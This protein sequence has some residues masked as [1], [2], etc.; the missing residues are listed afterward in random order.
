M[1]INFSA[2]QSLYN[3]QMN[4]LLANTGLTT[5]CLLNY[6]ITKKD[7]CPNCIYDPS[8]KK[9]AN[10]YKQ[11][12]PK[13]FV[14]GR[15]CPYCNGAGFNGLV[16]VEEAY[17][18]VIWE[19]KYWINK[20]INIQNPTGMIQT[21]C[22]RSLFDRLKKAKDLT[23]I[24][25]TNNNNPLFKLAEEPNPNGLGDNNYLICN[26]ERTGISSITESM[27]SKPLVGFNSANYL[28]PLGNI[29]LDVG[30]NG[31]PSA[32]GTYDQTGNAEEW[33]GSRNSQVGTIEI[34]VGGGYAGSS[35]DSILKGGVYGSSPSGVRYRGFR[36]ATLTNPNSYENYVLVD[37]KYNRN[38]TNGYGGVNHDYYINKYETTY[39]EWCEF[40]NSVASYTTS[41]GLVTNI[42]RD[43]IDPGVLWGNPEITSDTYGLLNDTFFS[44]VD[45]VA[46]T[47]FPGHYTFSVKEEYRNK[48]VTNMTWFNALRYCNWLH[49]TKPSG[50]QT[51]NNDG[52]TPNS[53]TT[54]GGAYSINGV[55]QL[56]TFINHNSSAKYRLPTID[57]WYKAAFYKNNPSTTSMTCYTPNAG[58]WKYATQSDILP[59]VKNTE[60]IDNLALH[61]VY[62]TSLG[63][64][65][66]DTVVLP[67]S[68][69]VDIVVDWGDGNIESYDTDG[70]KTHTYAVSGIYD[71]KVVGNLEYL[72]HKLAFTRDEITN[73]IFTQQEKLVECRNFGNTGLSN[74]D[75]FFMSCSELVSVPDTLPTEVES[76]ENTF[77]FCVAYNADTQGSG[78]LNW[79]VSNVTNM[80]QTFRYAI[81]FNQNIG[82]WDVSN[83]TTFNG[84]FRDA[85]DFDQDIGSWNIQSATNLSSMFYNAISFDRDI[86]AWNVSNVTDMSLLF[87]YSN[88]NQDINSWNVGN[89]TNMYYMFGANNTFNQS[90]SLWDV[91]NVTNMSYLFSGASAYNR[92]ITNWD[93]SNV[94]NM[95]HMFAGTSSFNQPLNSWNVTNV[96]NMNGLFK[97]SA[98]NRELSNWDVS[99]VTS[100]IEM[101]Y[102]N[103]QFNQDISMWDVSSVIS[104]GMVSMFRQSTAFNQDLSSWCVT[105]ITSIPNDF[106]NGAT[107]WVL[108]RPVWGTCP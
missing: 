26:W 16:K 46:P 74:L 23:V 62:N 53:S 35:V 37:D 107:A 84:M 14:N 96:T 42:D 55:N 5:K 77:A 93:V 78:V 63:L 98:Y 44:R 97:V 43:I 17:L 104:T 61:L 2:L 76:L 27:V 89:V 101:F 41:S 6:G 12:G 4:M 29:M 100:M 8:L 51:V 3:D 11:G 57:E 25:T 90:L 49:N 102:L 24:Y 73:N 79:D 36:T 75:R 83:V 65:N 15:I 40:I 31:G 68:S 86:S 38:D 69:P 66:T 54:E 33:T 88:F 32:Y 99:N 13:P 39:S 56:T 95:S 59:E 34:K 18:A 82:N 50:Y 108:S 7:L 58:Y 80:N 1:T 103:S 94:T 85:L 48:P 20:P 70:Q 64:N 105:N 92:S 9:S 52:I 10:K 87:G 21:I 45:Y 47:G 28:G 91:S 67:L 106:D 72:N 60:T 30:S 19:Y 81:A 22:H 71:V